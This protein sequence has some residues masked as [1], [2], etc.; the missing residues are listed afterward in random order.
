MAVG[1]RAVL[2]PACW[3]LLLLPFAADL[4]LSTVLLIFLLGVLAN[5]LIGGVL[6][7]ALAAVIAG[8]LANLLFTPPYGS[9]TI[10]QPENAF[11]LVVFVV[12]GVTVASVVDRSAGRASQAARGRAEAQ[13]VAAVATS[14]RRRGGPGARGAGAGQ[15]RVRHDVGRAAVDT[16]A[17]RAT[18]RRRRS[19]VGRRRACR[20][21]GGRP[22]DPDD[23][24]VAVAAGSD[25]V[26]ALYG[27]PLTPADRAWSRCSP[28]RRCSP[29]SGTG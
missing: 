13:L 10:S 19:G 18:S 15:G 20:P 28:R 17:V 26:L 8:L 16:A 9:L 11:A 5:A 12:V 2:I 29:S 21:T 24:D 1:W 7:A 3:P 6:P 4:A 27:R 25:W 22:V 23:A 14:V